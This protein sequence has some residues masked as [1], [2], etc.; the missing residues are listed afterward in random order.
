MFVLD[1]SALDE[2][3]G[4]IGAAAASLGCLDV[5][6]PF[7]AAGDALPG[8]ATLAACR[9]RATALDAA[10]DSYAL[11]LLDLCEIARRVARDAADTDVAV[12]GVLGAGTP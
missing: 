5:A 7:R 12:A 9:W 2:A 8:S 3:A 11:Q 4:H 1:P 10:V 6:G